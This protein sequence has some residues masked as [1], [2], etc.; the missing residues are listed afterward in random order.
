MLPSREGEF[1][2]TGSVPG[3]TA[4]G[5][6]WQAKFSSEST[7]KVNESFR[8]EPGIQLQLYGASSL[9]PP[10]S[11]NQSDFEAFGRTSE[12]N[13]F[14]QQNFCLKNQIRVSKGVVTNP[15]DKGPRRRK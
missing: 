14:V 15:S 13:N 10:P 6:S 11:P 2:T 1:K 5:S 8:K 7:H 12:P 3:Q 9:T 4:I